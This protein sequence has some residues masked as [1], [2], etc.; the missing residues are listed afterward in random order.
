MEDGNQHNKYAVAIIKDGEVV[1]S[2]PRS[3]SQILSNFLK[4]RCL[5]NVRCSRAL[6]FF[7]SSTRCLNKSKHLLQFFS[8]PTRH[9]NDIR[10][11][12]EGGVYTRKYSECGKE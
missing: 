9:L 5:L 3:I 1:G 10:H 7:G 11:W 6:Q 8:S 4:P 12:F 2:I